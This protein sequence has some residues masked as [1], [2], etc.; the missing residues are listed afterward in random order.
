MNT[1]FLFL[2][3]SF[4]GYFAPEPGDGGGGAGG[5]E[6]KADDKPADP[7]P[8]DKP[9]SEDKEPPAPSQKPEPKAEEKPPAKL[10]TKDETAARLAALE[11]ERAKDKTELERARTH[12]REMALEK[13]GVLPKYY[14]IV[15]DFDPWSKDT[16]TL[17]NWV[18]EHAEVLKPVVETQTR[19]PTAEDIG[20]N[21]KRSFLFNQES[22]ADG[23]RK[24]Q[25][26][27]L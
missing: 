3:T 5:S 1:R 22:Y 24:I 20:A 19:Q 6:P 8:E 14:D 21:G 15:P 23:L 4:P 25:E 27:N 11:A 26:L 2:L 17:D 7:K 12:A 10:E 9:K 16:R 13:A 18:K